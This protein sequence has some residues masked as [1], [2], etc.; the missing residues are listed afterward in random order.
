MW[1]SSS[2]AAK[3]WKRLTVTPPTTAIAA[4]W[5]TIRVAAG[6]LRTRT[7]RRD[8]IAVTETPGAL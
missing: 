3:M 8:T 5:S 7:Q 1:A 2:T 6:H 4:S